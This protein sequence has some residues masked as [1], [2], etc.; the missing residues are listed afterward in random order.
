MKNKFFIGSLLFLLF[1]GISI[2]FIV[3]KIHKEKI[4]TLTH[5]KYLT[6]SNNIKKLIEQSIIDKKEKG[7]TLALSLAT[8]KQYIE[9]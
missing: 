9:F 4:E 6:A 2:F 8:N 7:F 1:I 3:D 5:N